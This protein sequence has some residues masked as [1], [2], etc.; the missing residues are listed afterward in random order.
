MPINTIAYA[1]TLQAALDKKTVASLCSGW[2]EANAGQVLYTG[3][4]YIKIPKMSLTGLKDY[5]RDTGYKKGAVTLEYETLEMTMDRGTSFVI[6]A[7]DVDESNFIAAASTVAGEFQRTQ[8]VPEIDA[9]RYSKIAALT[10]TTQNSYTVDAAT[11]FDALHD[12]IAAVKNLVGETEE[13]VV[14]ISGTVKSKMEKLEKFAKYI[15]IAEF[16]QGEITTKVKSINDCPLLPVPSARMKSAYVFADGSTDGQ[17]GGGFTA[18]DD[19]QDINWIVAPKRAV[20]AVSKQ[21]KMK[22]FDPDTY[23]DAD[24]WFLGYRKYHDLWIKGSMLDAV[25]ANVSVP[26][27]GAV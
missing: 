22:I 3:G 2:M 27:G 6:D 26:K 20:I 23:Q 25:I 1:T 15:G 19:A 7:M 4:K 16:R 21:D 24:A 17:K 9:Y 13:V 18:A 12:D 8:V 10:E 14:S 11:V 5:D